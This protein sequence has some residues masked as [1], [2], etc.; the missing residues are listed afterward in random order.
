M[1]GRGKVALIP[2]KGLILSERRP[3]IGGISSDSL[4]LAFKLVE[5]K[6]LDGCIL[7]L[8]SP[9]GEIVPS[10]EISKLVEDTTV[11][12]VSLIR[13]SATSGA[14]LVACASDKIVADRLSV[15]GSVGVLGSYLEFSELLS[16]LGIEYHRIVGGEMKDMR[17]PFRKPTE[18]EKE[19]LQS[20]VN[21][22]HSEILEYVRRRRGVSEETISKLRDGRI[23]LGKEAKEMGLVDFL[24]GMKEAVSVMKGLAN[25]REVKLLEYKPRVPLLERFLTAGEAL[26]YRVG[27]GLA[28]GMFTIFYERGRELK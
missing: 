17:S 6:G 12:T 1:K 28:E 15:V 7:D 20:L 4:K 2:L 14:F 22:I 25:V 5:K 19:Y 24:G 21:S 8:N 13:G 9:G 16:K 23:M 26:A 10:R 18:K 27:A 3:F 11:P